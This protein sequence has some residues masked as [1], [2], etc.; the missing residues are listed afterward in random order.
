MHIQTHR[1]ND[2]IH[3][4]ACRSAPDEVLMLRTEDKGPTLAQK[5]FPIV[6]YSQMKISLSKDIQIT[7]KV[8]S[9]G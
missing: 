9:R 7:V 2:S 6:N 4:P 5:L 8:R 1:D 3:S